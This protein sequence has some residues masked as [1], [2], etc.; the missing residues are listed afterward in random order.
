M[1]GRDKDV[2][3]A[4]ENPDEVRQSKTDDAVFLFTRRKVRSVGYVL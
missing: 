2:K 3:A 4:L 1:N